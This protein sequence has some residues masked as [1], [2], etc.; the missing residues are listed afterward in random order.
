MTGYITPL[1]LFFAINII[2][3]NFKLNLFDALLQGDHRI[4]DKAENQKDNEK[5]RNEDTDI[6]ENADF[7]RK[8]K[9]ITCINCTYTDF[10][11]TVA[12]KAHII[13]AVRH[14]KKLFRLLKGIAAPQNFTSGLP[15]S[16]ERISEVAFISTRNSKNESAVKIIISKKRKGLAHSYYI[17]ANQLAFNFIKI[18]IEKRHSRI[19]TVDPAERHTEN[20]SASLFIAKEDCFCLT[21]DFLQLLKGNFTSIFNNVAVIFIGFSN[22][23]LF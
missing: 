10:S 17:A 14:C 23:A 15:V 12:W 9:N 13:T 5:N 16:Q 21:C 3:Y 18:Q 20:K 8:L 22:S 1:A 7:S 2:F 11:N 6:N 19:N 4:T